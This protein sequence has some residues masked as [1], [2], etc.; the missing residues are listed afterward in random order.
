[1][2]SV[3]FTKT[4]YHGG[5]EEDEDMDRDALGM[6]PS[7]SHAAIK[8]EAD[9]ETSRRRRLMRLAEELGTFGGFLTQQELEALRSES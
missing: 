5:P 4:K 6:T 2:Q 9:K 1:M 3:T 7:H 8:G